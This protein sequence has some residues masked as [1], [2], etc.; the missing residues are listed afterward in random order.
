VLADDN[1][2]A[3]RIRSAAS[4]RE[5]R[6]GSGAQADPLAARRFRRKRYSRQRIRPEGNRSGKT[7]PYRSSSQGRNSDQAQKAALPPPPGVRG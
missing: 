3:K 1:P 7:I 6:A 5:G 2:P 4:T